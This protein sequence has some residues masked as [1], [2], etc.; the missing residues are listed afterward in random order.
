[1]T[2][3][4][5]LPNALS[6]ARILLGLAFPFVPTDWR[7]GVVIA[8]AL[9]DLFDG[10]AARVLHAE[11]NAGRLLDPIADKVFVFLLAGTLIYEGAISPPWAVGLAARDIT[12]LIGLLYLTATR[13]WA[14]GRRL[15]PTLIGKVTTAAQFALLLALVIWPAVPGWAFLAVTLLSAIS[16]WDYALRFWRLR[17][18]PNGPESLS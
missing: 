9:S 2:P 13:Q 15:R 12:V 6:I 5:Y 18:P 4:H 3:L 11:S 14:W 1:M 10:L 16:A 8:A 7:L 17:E